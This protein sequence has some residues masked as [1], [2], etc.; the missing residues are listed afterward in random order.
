[1]AQSEWA[2]QTV[3]RIARTIREA[4]G[5]RSTQWLADRTKELGHPI[6]RVA[7]S[8]LEVGRKSGVDVADLVIL[9]RALEVPPM[10]LIY[11]T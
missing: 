3:S 5:V 1:M 10:M 2:E 7:I 4:R 11:R 9:A 8:N 6:S